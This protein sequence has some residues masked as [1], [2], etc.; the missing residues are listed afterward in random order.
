MLNFQYLAGGARATA[1]SAESGVTQEWKGFRWDTAVLGLAITIYFRWTAGSWL[2]CW[3]SWAGQGLKSLHKEEQLYHS[4]QVEPWPPEIL[5]PDISFSSGPELSERWQWVQVFDI[6]LCDA[7][8][9]AD[10]LSWGVLY[11]STWEISISWTCYKFMWLLLQSTFPTRNTAKKQRRVFG[12]RSFP[13]S[14]QGQCCSSSTCGGCGR[15]GYQIPLLH[16]PASPTQACQALQ[17]MSTNTYPLSRWGTNPLQFRAFLC[18]SAQGVGWLLGE[19]QPG[20]GS[21]QGSRVAYLL[22]LDMKTDLQ[23]QLPNPF[24]P[25]TA[26]AVAEIQHTSSNYPGHEVMNFLGTLRG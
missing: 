20:F 18:L 6:M 19:H 15:M 26:L 7:S 8:H 11:W 17:E 16:L 5:T 2:I 14:G 21:T 13:Q 23:Q 1:L 10:P 25:T 22:H 24:V 9:K 4:S 12:S 3:F